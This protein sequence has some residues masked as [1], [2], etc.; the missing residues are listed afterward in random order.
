MRHVVFD[1][2]ETLAHSTPF[3]RLGWSR[4]IEEL[5]L[6]RTLAEL[7]PFETNLRERFDSY[8]RVQ[9]GF[10]NGP[11]REK[12]VAYFGETDE[13][14][15]AKKIVDLKES[16]TVRAML[17]ASPE[18]A[19]SLLAKNA[20]SALDILHER[21]IRLGLISS[22]RELI[23]HTF[24]FRVG[25]HDVFDF[26]MG[27]ESLTDSAGILHDKPNPYALEALRAKGLNID[28][29]IGDSG[30]I[31]KKFAERCHAKFIL[32]NYKTDLL[33]LLGNI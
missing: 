25:L 22:T 24:L 19:F 8:R 29:Y 14:S 13:Y 31:D 32:A 3:H 11:V 27:E 33:E 1:F 21:H 20:V 23:I 5:R 12:V 17:D 9:R 6:G 28:V 7:L 15:L 4:T 16:L 18:E 2:D 26:V 10:L 30:S